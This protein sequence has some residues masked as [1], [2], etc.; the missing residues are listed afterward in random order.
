MDIAREKQEL[1]RMMKDRMLGVDPISFEPWSSMIIGRIESSGPFRRATLILGYVALPDEPGMHS[2]CDA[3]LDMGKRVAFP[4][5]MPDG[6]LEFR[7]VGREWRK[8]LVSNR[9]NIGEP[10]PASCPLINFEKEAAVV[11]LVPGVAFSVRRERL[12]R[13]KGFYDR[14]LAHKREGMTSI[15]VC[16]DHQVLMSIPMGSGD[17]GV[18]MLATPGAFY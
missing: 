11:V 7:Q 1:R 5:C 6:S 9:W 17:M 15:G 8:C 2:L 3:A 18:D 13:G 16:F 4:A 12:G 14:F 10:D